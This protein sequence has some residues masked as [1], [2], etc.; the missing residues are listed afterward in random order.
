MYKLSVQNLQDV[1][2][3]IVLDDYEVNTSNYQRQLSHLPR[4]IDSA[5]T[6]D[7]A[8]RR[9]N[10]REYLSISVVWRFEKQ[11]VFVLDQLY[12]VDGCESVRTVDHCPETNRSTVK[13][14]PSSLKLF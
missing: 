8:R 10:S 11:T 12:V 4:N 2:S 5:G 6:K 13:N 14:V 3:S 7:L 9:H 1:P